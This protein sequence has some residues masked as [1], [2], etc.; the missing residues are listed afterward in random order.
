MVRIICFLLFL[1]FSFPVFARYTEV[2]N[3]AK[4]VPERYEKNLSSLVDYLIRPYSRNEELKLRAIFA[5]IAYHIEYDMFSYEV[6]SDKKKVLRKNKLVKTGDAFK[7]RVGVCADISDLFQRMAK[8]AKIKSEEVVGYAGYDLTMDNYKENKH[9]WNA[10]YINNK[11]FFVDATWAMSGDYR[12]FEGIRTIAEHRKEVRK[13]R[14]D[15]NK[16]VS[17]NRHINNKWFMVTPEEMIK[18]HF[19]DREKQQYLRPT[20]DYK[21]VFRENARRLEKDRK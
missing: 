21:K 16:E 4:D 7:S 3:Y 17:D 11:W 18:T 5:W 10:V 1:I 9:A 12:A 8:L 20:I 14:Q 19:P 6:R 13:K 15:K 2:D